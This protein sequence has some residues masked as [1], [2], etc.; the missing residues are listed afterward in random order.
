MIEMGAAVVVSAGGEYGSDCDSSSSVKATS[1][2][3]TF[4]TLEFDV[5][6]KTMPPFGND[7]APER[8]STNQR[9]MAKSWACM[10]L[11]PGVL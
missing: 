8:W 6:A 5:A 4:G 2:V 9:T 10:S 3:G 11:K 7:V 1:R